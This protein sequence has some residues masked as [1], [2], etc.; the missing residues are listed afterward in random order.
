[1][2]KIILEADTETGACVVKIDDQEYSDISDVNIYKYK[3]YQ[4]DGSYKDKIGYGVATCKKE[5][6]K[7]YCTQIMASKVSAEIKKQLNG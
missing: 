1:M 5:N 4:E 2:S 3:A 7:Y 6:G